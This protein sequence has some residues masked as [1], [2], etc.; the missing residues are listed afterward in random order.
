MLEAQPEKRGEVEHEHAHRHHRRDDEDPGEGHQYR[1]PADGERHAG[2]DQRAEHDHEREGGQRE[3]DHLRALEVR[4]GHGLHIAVEGRSAARPHR[5]SRD[6]VEA[7]HH[8]GDRVG[9]VVGREVEEHDVVGGVAVG[10]DLARRED[11]R[12]DPGHVRRA[13][14]V[15]GRGLDRRLPLRRP[16]RQRVRRV[17]EH[18]RRGFDAELV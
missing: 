16:G 5:L 12:Q 1:G 6:L 18:E 3:R 4:L 11:V 7:G 9:R 15:P 14:D 17:E 10:G 13:G 2:R 8:A